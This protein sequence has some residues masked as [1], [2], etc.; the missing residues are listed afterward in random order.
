MKAISDI[1]IYE[2]GDGGDFQ[3]VNDD[4]QVINGLTNQVYLALFGGNKE[5]NDDWWGNQLLAESNQMKSNFERVLTEVALNSAGLKTIR[6]TALKDLAFL[7]DIADVSVDANIID[8][9]KLELLVTL[10]Q[11]DNLS[12][13]LKFLWDGTNNEII[14]E[15]IL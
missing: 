6:E 2:T 3:L 10:V 12:T 9:N 14:E 1:M 11:P 7:K 8:Y 15:I 4:L 5:K 13:K